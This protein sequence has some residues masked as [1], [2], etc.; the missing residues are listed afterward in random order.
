MGAHP[1]RTALYV[2]T[3]L[4]S[5]LHSLFTITGTLSR[6]SRACVYFIIPSY[7]VYFFPSKPDLANL[8]EFAIIFAIFDDFALIQFDDLVFM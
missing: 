5:Y 1:L 3:V 8:D 7:L 4:H 6:D 2:R